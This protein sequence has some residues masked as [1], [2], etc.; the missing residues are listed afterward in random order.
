MSVLY[1][2][3]TCDTYV[4]AKMKKSMGGVQ[5]DD[6]TSISKRIKLKEEIFSAVNKNKPDGSSFKRMDYSAFR[7]PSGPT[8]SLINVNILLNYIETAGQY[9]CAAC[10]VSLNSESQFGQH[11]VHYI[12]S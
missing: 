1:H 12:L 9:Y 7:T 5:N 10:N 11:Q 8:L 3:L 2:V 4:Q 6:L